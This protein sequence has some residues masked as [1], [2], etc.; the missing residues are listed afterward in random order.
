MSKTKK[1]VHSAGIEHRG[2]LVKTLIS[3]SRTNLLYELNNWLFD[4]LHK[5]GRTIE[6]LP[7]LDDWDHSIEKESYWSILFP[8][9]EWFI[10][11]QTDDV[12]FSK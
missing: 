2:K 12:E 8:T 3:A 4:Y 11:I 10:W 5:T 1:L 6:H 7:P 9:D